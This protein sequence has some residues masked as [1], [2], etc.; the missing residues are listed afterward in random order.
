M[1]SR[2]ADIGSEITMGS[3]GNGGYPTVFEYGKL[4]VLL[5]QIIAIVRGV[6]YACNQSFVVYDDERM[7]LASCPEE[8]ENECFPKRMV[9]SGK[10]RL[11]GI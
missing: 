8:T 9:T 11:S 7:H 5:A 6:E 10:T 2:F 4:L 3:A 1:F